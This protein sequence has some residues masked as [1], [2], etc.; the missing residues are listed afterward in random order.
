MCK[1][2]HQHHYSGKTEPSKCPS[3][4]FWLSK[5]RYTYKMEYYTE[6]KNNNVPS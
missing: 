4:E 1:D 3:V 5:L 2:G 6:I